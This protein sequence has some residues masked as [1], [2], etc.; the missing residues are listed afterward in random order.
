MHY[1]LAE[2]LITTNY[3]AWWQRTRLI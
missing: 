3:S 2:T 1:N